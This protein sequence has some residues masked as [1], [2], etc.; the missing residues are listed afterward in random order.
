M[1]YFSKPRVYTESV[2]KAIST[3]ALTIITGMHITKHIARSLY[4]LSD[5]ATC[6][7]NIMLV[8]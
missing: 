2:L 1:L 4:N 8:R 6:R 7:W 5:S 3:V